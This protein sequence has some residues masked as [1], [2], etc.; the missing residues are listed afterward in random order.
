MVTQLVVLLYNKDAIVKI[1]LSIVPKHFKSRKLDSF[2]FSKTLRSQDVGTAVSL[3]SSGLLID[4][5]KYGNYF[6]YYNKHHGN[7]DL[8]LIACFYNY[9]S[10][11]SCVF[12]CT[13]SFDTS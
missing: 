12:T 5:P 8:M 10:I 9:M 6:V 13:C 7:S 11:K 4:M 1:S 2:C 3:N